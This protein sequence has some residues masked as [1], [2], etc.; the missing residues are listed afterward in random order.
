MALSFSLLF[1]II[2]CLEL[3][4]FLSLHCQHQDLTVTAFS[5]SRPP[6]KAFSSFSLYS[7]NI[8]KKSHHESYST[9]TRL[10]LVVPDEPPKSIVNKDATTTTTA[11]NA[12]SPKLVNNSNMRH[13]TS[14]RSILSS[15]V[16][17][18]LL[19]TLAAATATTAT[20]NHL[21]A[22]AMVGSLPEYS[23]S[24]SVLQGI[25]VQVSDPFQQDEMIAFLQDGFGMT[26][27]RQRTQGS[28][29]D[30]WMAF[31]PEQMSI[32]PEWEPGVSSLTNYGGHASIN[33]RYDSQITETFYK[34]GAN[35]AAPGDNIAYLQMGVP[36]YR[37]SQMVRHG[38]NV[39]NGYGIVEVVSPSGLPIRGV[40]GISP[41]PIMFIAINCQNVKQSQE[42]YQQIGFVPQEYPY[43]R[44]NKGMGQFE[45]PQPKKS[46][47]LAPSK[48]SMGVLLLPSKNKKVS[49]KPNPAIQS[50]NIVYQPSV[51]GLEGGNDD[52]GAAS[53]DADLLIVKDPSSVPIAFEPIEYFSRVEQRTRITPTI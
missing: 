3:F 18:I 22:N 16:N 26:K 29:T 36:N 12:A 45:P 21:V 48:D 49:P 37:I 17:N 23:D 5:S 13:T 34:M 39:Y 4:C 1:K 31:G 8:A 53:T 9:S 2:S 15:T 41:D 33:I 25:T 24:N 46:V 32:P 6:A 11:T 7:S 28:V 30:T 19:T 38:G 14:R 40:I 47:Y 50:L 42:F 44:P 43:C 27:V 51:V 35:E 10:H 20:N 52:G